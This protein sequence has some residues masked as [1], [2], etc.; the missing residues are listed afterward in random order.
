MIE[1]IL[2]RD[3]QLKKL[4][5]RVSII[6]YNKEYSKTTKEEREEIIKQIRK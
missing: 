3:Y 4:K 5:E 6:L 1:C 2:N